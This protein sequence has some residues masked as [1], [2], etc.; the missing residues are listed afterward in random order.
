MRPD[1]K[2]AFGE[3][4]NSMAYFPL[5]GISVAK[6]QFQIPRYRGARRREGEKRAL[7]ERECAFVKG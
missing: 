6:T 3:F 4:G 2:V 7:I 1:I 5:D